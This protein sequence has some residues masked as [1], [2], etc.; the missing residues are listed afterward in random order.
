M[1]PA[2]LTIL[3]RTAAGEQKQRHLDPEGLLKL[4]HHIAAGAEATRHNR[5]AQT[6]A[7]LRAERCEQSVEAMLEQRLGGCHA[8]DLFKAELQPILRN[9]QGWDHLTQGARLGKMLREIAKPNRH[10]L[11]RSAAALP[12]PTER[13]HTSRPFIG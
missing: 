4:T 5:A 8:A 13:I 11:N 6:L 7:R 10:D 12:Q 3:G 2:E 1:A 9:P